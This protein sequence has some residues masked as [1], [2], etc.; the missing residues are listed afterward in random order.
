MADIS[1]TKNQKK[2]DEIYEY[3]EAVNKSAS[4]WKST[5]FE[6]KALAGEM[7]I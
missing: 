1:D 2:K 3:R 5:T 7:C 6:R 4:S